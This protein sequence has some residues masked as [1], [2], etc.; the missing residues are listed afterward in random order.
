MLFTHIGVVVGSL[1][2]TA[3]AQAGSVVISINPK[4]TYLHTKS[5]AALNSP[6]LELASLG[7]VAGDFVRITRLGAF[8][9]G[10]QSDQYT[11]LLGVFSN[12]PTLLDSS[13]LHR[14]PGAIDA[15]PEFVSAD[16]WFGDEPTDIPQDF[17]ISD[18][19]NEFGTFCLVVPAGAT[20]IFL[21]PH[22]SL[23]NDNTDPNADFKAQFEVLPPPTPDVNLDGAVDGA[24]LGLLLGAWGDCVEGCCPADINGDGFIDGADLGLLLG[25]WSL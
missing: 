14:V 22:D 5:D 11:S 20:H 7:V 13:L 23:Y 16:T 9:N 24:D 19:I 25:S 4:A 15:G 1:A 18:S 10:P 17:R 3:F 6:A 2:V 12:G 8:D 21:A